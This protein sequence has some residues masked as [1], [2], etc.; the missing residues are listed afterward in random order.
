MMSPDFCALI[1]THNRADRIK[2]YKTLRTS[3]YTGKIF[4]V[5]DDEDPALDDY[6]RLYDWSEILVFSKNDYRDRFDVGDNFDNTK[7][8]IYARNACHDLAKAAGYRYFVELDDDYTAFYLRHNAKYEYGNTPRLR[9]TL[10]QVFE[11]IL[12]YYKS[13]PQITTIAL[14]QG[15]DHIGGNSGGGNHPR[16][17]RKSMNSFFCDVERPFQFSGRL[18]DDVNTYVTLGSR[19][20]LFFTVMQAQLVQ[21]QTQMSSGGLTEVYLEAGTYVKSFYSVMYAP[22]FVKVK[23]LGDPRSPRY[24]LHHSINWHNAVPKILREEHRK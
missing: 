10:D 11:A 3:G 16:L 23:D 13:V 24:R 17:M 14:S 5:V 18:N 7:S 9:K 12:D 4:L 2:T 20:G 8:V 1:L 6:R 21:V 19:G 15:G 22:S